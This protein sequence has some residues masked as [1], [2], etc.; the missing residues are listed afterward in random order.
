MTHDTQELVAE[1]IT[2]WFGP[3]CEAR[4]TD[5]LP[6]LRGKSE[7]R[8]PECNWRMV[9][10]ETTFNDFKV[11]PVKSDGSLTHYRPRPLDPTKID[12]H[13]KPHTHSSMIKEGVYPQSRN[14]AADRASVLEK[15]AGTFGGRFEHFGNGRF[16]YVAYTD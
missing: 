15:V 3:R 1:A 13:S 2:E 16:K 14:D 9:D 5:E 10:E 4:D 6:E 8:C 11:G 12:W 7:G